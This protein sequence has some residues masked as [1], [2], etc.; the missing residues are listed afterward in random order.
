MTN[1][2]HMGSRESHP[3]DW[4]NKANAIHGTIDPI[5]KSGKAYFLML[6]R[7]SM[8][9]ADVTLSSFKSYTYVI[10]RFLFNSDRILWILTSE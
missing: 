5:F 3:K 6:L 2:S 8:Y 9:I 4:E 7:K 10:S 1:R